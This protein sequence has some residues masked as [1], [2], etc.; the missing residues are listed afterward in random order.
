[1]RQLSTASNGH[2]LSDGGPKTAPT[3]SAVVRT[4]AEQ[5]EKIARLF[6]ARHEQQLTATGNLQQHLP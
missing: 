6:D 1:M 4:N 5:E 2:H 3:T